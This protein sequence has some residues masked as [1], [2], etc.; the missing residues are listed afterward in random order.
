[1][2]QSKHATDIFIIFLHPST[3]VPVFSKG[4]EVA[5]RCT[6]TLRDPGR[7]RVSGGEFWEVSPGSGNSLRERTRPRRCLQ[8]HRGLQLPRA[9]RLAQ[10]NPALLTGPIREQF[11]RAA[12]G[13]GRG[14]SGT[15]AWPGT[16]RG[17]NRWKRPPSPVA[18]RLSPATCRVQLANT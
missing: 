3:T 12:A 9:G 16:G 4:R 11:T 6:L 5:I 2:E 13:W 18:E 8:K 7:P 1:M 15:W 14:P 17:S 10:A